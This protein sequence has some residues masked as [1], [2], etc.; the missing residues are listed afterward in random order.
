MIHC[1]PFRILV[2]QLNELPVNKPPYLASEHPY[3]CLAYCV[4]SYPFYPHKYIYNHIHD[5]YAY[6]CSFIHTLLYA[7]V[8][9]RHIYTHIHYMHMPY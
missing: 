7:Y 3:Q 2:Q 6:T 1:D 9:I 4:L 8:Y 5:T